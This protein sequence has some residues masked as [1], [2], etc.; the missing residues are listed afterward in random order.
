MLDEDRLEALAAGD[1][2]KANM[3]SRIIR[4]ET[5]HAT[6]VKLSQHWET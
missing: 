1:K 2:A 6:F 4:A 5:T 3:I